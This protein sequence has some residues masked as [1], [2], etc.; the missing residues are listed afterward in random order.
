MRHEAGYVAPTRELPAEWFTTEN[1][2]AGKVSDFYETEPNMFFTKKKENNPAGEIERAYHALHRGSLANEL[3]RR[4][5]PKGRTMAEYLRQEFPDV[6]VFSGIQ[7]ESILNREQF[8]R[9][10]G[11]GPE[12]YYDSLMS[13]LN[14]HQ[15]VD[16]QRVGREF[17]SNEDKDTPAPVDNIDDVWARLANAFSVR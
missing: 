5:E 4:V 15:K 17:V 13:K 16:Q 11:K 6:G 2:K 14:D 3:F 9:S 10:N 1:I 8:I 12:E 7:E